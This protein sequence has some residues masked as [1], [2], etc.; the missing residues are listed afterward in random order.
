[1]T[2]AFSDPGTHPIVALVTRIHDDLDHLD[3]TFW[4]MSERDL[5]AT[6][7]A[8]TRLRQRINSLELSAA[9][10]ADTIGLG[11]EVGAADTGAYWAN[12]T[13]QPKDVAKHRLKLADALDQ[14][15]V[16]RTAMAEGRVAED[17]AAV[18]IKAVDAL[19]AMQAEAE[20]ELV[21]LAAHHDAKELGLLARRVLDVVAPEVAEAHELAV[22]Q[23]EE[24]RAREQCRFTIT[25]DGH[26]QAYI[27]GKV[28]SAIGAMVKKQL[29]AINA[30]KARLRTATPAGPTP[31]S[32]SP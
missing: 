26:G 6:L 21:R 23:R 9:H 11:T 15:D 7:P 13:R 24:D 5:A 32:W 10:Q 27:R 25:D 14:H 2:T 16:T 30:P 29:L 20:T 17:Q 4:S 22:L 1:M 31:R 28:P 12:T 8:L 19:P 18:I 3:A